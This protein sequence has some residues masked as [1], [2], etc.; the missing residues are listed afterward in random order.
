MIKDLIKDKKNI[1]ISVVIPVY[2]CDKSLIELHDRLAVTLKKIVKKYEIIF[3]DDCGPGNP[4]HLIK[5]ISK[6]NKSVVGVKLSRNFGQHAAIIAGLENSNGELLVV[7]DC[8][9]QDQPEEIEGLYNA[10]LR[11]ETDIVFAKR[12]FRK[13]SLIK[14]TS[15]K[16]FYTLLGYLTETKI[17]SSVANFGIFN[18]KTIDAVLSMTEAH[19]YF[20]IMVR[21]VGFSSKSISTV[22]SNRLHDS[23]SYTFNSLVKLSLDVIM[24]FSNKPLKLIVRLGFMISFLS[25]FYA[26][27]IVIDVYISKT[28]VPGWSSVMVSIWFI[29]GMLMSIVGVVGLYV[30]KTFDESKSRPVFIVDEFVSSK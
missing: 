2:G 30:G 4:W 5:E 13:D 26:I 18:R 28:S 1:N 16:L 25:A 20:P 12:T 21:W 11:E 3:V 29:G 9:L 6:I 24:S 14:K 22:H 23:S 8:D 17:D 15:S 27:L 19:K 10:V 7:M